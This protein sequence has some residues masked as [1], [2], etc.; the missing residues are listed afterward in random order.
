M[1]NSNETVHLGDGAPTAVP[2]STDSGTPL[3][4]IEIDL[5]DPDQCHFGA[6][7]LIERIGGGGMGVVYRAHQPSL[8]RDVAIK[9][10][11]LQLADDD[12]ALERFRFEAKSAAALN[13][14]NIVQILEIGQ[15]RGLAYIAMQLVRGNTLADRIHK[16]RFAPRE[17]VAMMLEICDAVG[18]AHRLS[19]LHLDLKP[20]NV[21]ID[22]RGE[23]LVA[24]FGLARRMDADGEVEAQEVS[25]TP[26]YMAP[27]Q[28]LIKEYRLSAATDIY[29]LGAILYEMMCGISPHGRGEAATVMRRVRE[30]E[31]PPLR[32]IAPKLPR[33]LEAI[34]T[35][36]LSLRAV[37][38]YPSV[39]RFA[40][41]LRRF[42]N[43]LAVSVRTPGLSERMQRWYAREPRFALALTALMLLA[44]VG[45]TVLASLYKQA[46]D[47]RAGA[48]GIVRVLMAQTPDKDQAIIQKREGFKVPLIDCSLAN[49]HCNG[50][51]DPGST[52][53]P[54]LR[55]EKRRLYLDA[56]R[57]YVPK[58]ASWGRPRLSEQLATML[59][60][61]RRDLYRARRARAAAATG[62]TDGFVFAWL[63]AG[64]GS[65]DPELSPR[66]AKAWLEQAVARIDRPWQAQ[67]LVSTCDVVDPVCQRAIVRFQQIDP[68][69]AAAWLDG[70]PRDSKDINA[71]YDALLLHAAS[72]HRLS[73]SETEISD[74]A[75]AFGTILAPSLE[76]D[77]RVSPGDF[78]IEAIGRLG[79]IRYPLK[80]CQVSLALR[81]A[82]EIEAAC[83]AIHAKIQPAMHPWLGDEIVA[84]T[85]AM[86]TAP[87]PASREEARRRLRNVRWIYS[88][89]KQLPPA[90]EASAGP[91]QLRMAHAHGDLAYVRSLV[92]K[93]GLPVE[94]PAE[95]VT[96]EPLPWKR[97]NGAAS[98]SGL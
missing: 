80:Y 1:S 33:D 87:D 49:V 4:D 2:R 74:V 64:N 81:D 50:D 56:L 17:A 36:C 93:A 61:T 26:A 65:G 13:H 57:A 5:N 43:G 47:E 79:V 8:E 62:T 76:G 23:P 86:S 78:A 82:P 27:E 25:G 38:R 98:G 20:A 14:P 72:T 9:L 92:A 11:D 59:D 69:N 7:T 45:S 3:G 40:E 89:W 53:D 55:V 29:A 90:L 66:Q 48:E 60:N 68:D 32:Q 83:N 10:L 39:E 6:Y 15:K 88:V 58:I 84:A 22:E 34:C 54:S 94:A 41:D 24:D 85:Y 37:D 18:Y 28:V 96:R 73:H 91:Y 52:I 51:L 21:L 19:L 95:F 77:A 12:V 67:V 30:G 44:I 63:L 75:T 42:Q 97:H 35:K 46:S 16:Q 71:R 70:I 31:I